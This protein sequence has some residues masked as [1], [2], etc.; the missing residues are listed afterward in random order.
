MLTWRE[1]VHRGAGLL[2]ISMR[3][4]LQ[5]MK[6]LLTPLPIVLVTAWLGV[7]ALAVSS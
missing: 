3:R 5:Q 7:V 6:H 1:Q 2:S 4:P